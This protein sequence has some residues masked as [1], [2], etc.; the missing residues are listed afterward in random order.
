MKDY[1]VI[2]LN[3][4][5]VAY[6]REVLGQGH[7]LA[8]YLLEAQPLE[9]GRVFTFVPPELNISEDDVYASIREGGLLPSPP[10]E[11]HRKVRGGVFRPTPTTSNLLEEILCNYLETDVRNACIFE[12]FYARQSDPSM[13][14]SDPPWVALNDEVYYCLPPS[15]ERRLVNKVIF[16]ASDVYPGAIGAMTVWPE[17]EPV[18]IAGRTITADQLRVLAEHATRII[19]GAFDAEGYLIWTK[20]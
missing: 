19:I 20:N 7:T 14:S 15:S 13:G 16:D 12:D 3:P 2:D 5:V 17:Q 10:P 8:R 6:V 9:K 4:S 11:T 1:R 18:E